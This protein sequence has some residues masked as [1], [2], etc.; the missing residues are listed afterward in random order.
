MTGSYDGE[1]LSFWVSEKSPRGVVRLHVACANP[2]P[3]ATTTDFKIGDNV[4][5][6]L[7]EDS[8]QTFSGMAAICDRRAGTHG[9]VHVEVLAGAKDEVDS[10]FVA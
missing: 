1:V 5:F 7:D 9:F 2:I 10:I 3:P 4:D 6:K 8:D